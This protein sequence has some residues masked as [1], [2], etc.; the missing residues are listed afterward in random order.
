MITMNLLR[1]EILKSRQMMTNWIL[2]L[3]VP[4]LCFFFLGAMF[5]GAKI[6]GGAFLDDAKALFPFPFS[7]Y[8]C[9]V[10][11]ANF[12]SLLSI[13]YVA[14][15]VGNEYSRDTWKMILPRYSSRTAF[16]ATK[17]LVALFTMLL[18]LGLTISFWL[19]FSYISALL[20]NINTV[21]PLAMPD[22]SVI[23]CVKT[24]GLT[25]LRIVF[26]GAVTCLVTISFRSV[27]GGVIAGT[28]LSMVLATVAEVPVKVLA[29]LLPTLHINNIEYHWLKDE[30]ALR[31]LT[32]M[33]GYSISTNTS[34]AIVITYILLLV[35]LSF[36]L[37]HKRD[38]SGLN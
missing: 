36:Y 3:I 9:S 26:Y 20:L 8:V 4:L 25:T 5:L 18:F 30:K 34:L 2:V 37:F 29:L 32:E 27:I 1:A 21:D 28:G 10:T 14:N 23:N 31:A 38:I 7:F 15:S 33:F 16:L 19:S 24:I 6:K 11:I 12:A 35:G 22:A 13:V 17:L